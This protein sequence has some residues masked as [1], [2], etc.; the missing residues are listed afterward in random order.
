MHNVLRRSGRLVRLGVVAQFRNPG[1]RV[2][3][4]AAALGA[5]AYAW[6][7]G[8]V[9]ASTGVVLAAWLGRAFGA[10]A[11]LW[12]AYNAI[13]DQNERSGAT[14]RSKPVDGAYWVLINL[15]SGLAVWLSML[16]FC[17]LAA[18]LAQLPAAG[19]TSVVTHAWAF[20]RAALTVIIVG[21]LSFALSRAMRS[22]LGG[23]LILF[24][25][26]CAMGG[27]QFVPSYLRP[28]YAQ[29][30][31]L[32]L[33]V[34]A[35]M[36]CLAALF[37]E[38]FRRGELR[39][40]LAPLAVILVFSLAAAAGAVQAYSAVPPL[41]DEVPTVWGR[42]ANQHI[43]PGNRA[44]GFW[45]P[46]GRG[47]VVRT[48][49]FPGK[50]L[51]IYIFAPD[52]MDAARTLPALEQIHKEFGA[53]GVQPIG[54]CLSPDHGDGVALAR[55]GGYHFPIGS[56]L[57]TLKSTVPLET[58][59]ATAYDIQLMPTLVVTDRRW[60]VHDILSEPSTDAERLR[61]L[62]NERLSQEPE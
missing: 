41:F 49:D 48:A 7:M 42:I 2:L 61:Q 45:L 21:T 36:I 13:R 56:D 52:D 17:F 1:M 32:F 58:A 3:A 27:L 19:L 50:I 51:L 35:V 37:I 34:A 54:V 38:R 11:C 5:G 26:F 33:A 14:L 39:R 55:T 46:D 6:S 9:A 4:I 15:I 44:P 18:A 47:G 29:N 28:D 10:A 60:R 43:Q 16:A 59:V 62:V 22:P 40:P 57:T 31:V 12:F 30:R 20:G 53:K 8:N 23:I 24:A 25:W